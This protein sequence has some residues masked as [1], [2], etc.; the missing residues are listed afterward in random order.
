VWQVLLY[1]YL[2][3]RYIWKQSIEMFPYYLSVNHTDSS[4]IQIVLYELFSL[5]TRIS[6]VVRFVLEMALP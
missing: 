4:V 3:L 1:V 2:Q 6:N 5:P